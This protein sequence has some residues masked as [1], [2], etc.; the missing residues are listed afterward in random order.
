MHCSACFM[1]VF[2]HKNINDT[3]VYIQLVD[4]ADDEYVSRVAKTVDEVRKLVESGFEYVSTIE[5][6]QIY[7]KRK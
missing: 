4:L 2:V 3:L 1:K 7:R 5:D 6:T